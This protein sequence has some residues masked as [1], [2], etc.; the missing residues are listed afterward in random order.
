VNT[1]NDLPHKVQLQLPHKRGATKRR[2]TEQ[3][4][5]ARGPFLSGNHGV[6]RGDLMLARVDLRF[7]RGQLRSFGFAQ[8][9]LR[10]QRVELVERCLASPR[11]LGAGLAQFL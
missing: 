2:R 4:R 6:G 8:L 5:A 10:E 7:E 1:A 11:L 9:S 3:G